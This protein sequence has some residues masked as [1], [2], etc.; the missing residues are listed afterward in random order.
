MIKLVCLAQFTF[1]TV[2]HFL[3]LA[4]NLYY[5]FL[6][7]KPGPWRAGGSHMTSRGLFYHWFILNM[8]VKATLVHLPRHHPADDGPP[9]LAHQEAHSRVC[10]CVPGP[11]HK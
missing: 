11:A 7:F 4:I 1:M 5:C 2:T 9:T 6:D 3:Y 8:K 10:D